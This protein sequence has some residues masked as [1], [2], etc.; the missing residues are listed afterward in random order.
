M[1]V[2]YIR[3]AIPA[4]RRE[5]F[6]RAYADA[7]PALDASPHCLAYDLARCAEDPTQFVLRIEWDSV[8]A[9]TEGFRGGALFPEW[10]S[11]WG[12]YLD[13]TPDV[14]HY[15]VIAGP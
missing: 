9:H 11:H 12:E 8:G 10:R 15:Q 5:S 3:Y 6:E 14:Q 13:G 7:A 1:I 4:D 2:E